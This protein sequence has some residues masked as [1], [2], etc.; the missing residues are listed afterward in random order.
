MSEGSRQDWWDEQPA[1][2]GK[3]PGPSG[4][5]KHAGLKASWFLAFLAASFFAMLFSVGIDFVLRR[6]AEGRVPVP[7]TLLER[8]DLCL[9]IG[10]FLL[11]ACVGFAFGR[12]GRVGGT[13]AATCSF[14][15]ALAGMSYLLLLQAGLWQ[16]RAYD[17][18]APDLQRWL[19]ER[20]LAVYGLAILGS[21]VAWFLPFRARSD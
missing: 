11:G 5:S 20:S 21:L 10:L 4:S 14:L 8:L 9:G 6:V 16:P 19:Q 13:R 18:E 3:A 7:E 15:L 2:Q 12:L 17:L 1:G